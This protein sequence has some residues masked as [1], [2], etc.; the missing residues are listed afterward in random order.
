MFMK[1]GSRS[2]IYALWAGARQSPGRAETRSYRV[3]PDFIQRVFGSNAVTRSVTSS[4]ELVSRDCGRGQL[5][6]RLGPESS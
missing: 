2:P 4:Q 3:T 6:G 5:R 1:Q